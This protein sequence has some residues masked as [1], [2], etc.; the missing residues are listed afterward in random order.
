MTITELLFGR[1]QLLFSMILDGE[2]P[3]QNFI[4][5]LEEM[6]YKQI[7]QLIRFI[8]DHGPP[9]NIRKFRYLGDEIYELKTYRGV[10]IFSFFGEPT[11]PKS[12]ILTHG[13]FKPKKKELRREIKK[14]VDFRED[15]FESVDIIE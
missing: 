8:S 13:M 1:G 7:M 2:S 12:L 11:L 14:T 5:G 10:R 6:D 9:A 15:F 3:V 4:D